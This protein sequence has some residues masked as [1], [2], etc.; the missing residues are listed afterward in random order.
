MTDP[1]TGE[2]RVLSSEGR[3]SSRIPYNDIDVEYITVI[4]FRQDFEPERMAWGWEVIERAERPLFKVNELDVFDEGTILSLFVETTRWFGMKM[5]F[6]AKDL[7]DQQKTRTRSK[8]T[9]ERGI[10]PISTN[11]ITDVTRGRTFEL[12]FS[13][14]F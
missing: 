9:G 12:T 1:V 2:N 6:A 7:L 10:T 4:N 5:Q 3:I 11:E 13:G 8:Y 14:S